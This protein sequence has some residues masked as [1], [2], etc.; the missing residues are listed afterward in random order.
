M[1]KLDRSRK[2]GTV[3]GDPEKFFYQDGVFFGANDL[4]VGEAESV[5]P[6][7]TQEPVSVVENKDGKADRIAKLKEV[8]IAKL[9]KMAATL[10]EELGV[11]PPRVAGTGVKAKLVK[12]IADRTE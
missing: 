3:Y 4:A 7:P 8:H 2:Y 10:A 9:K 1:K 5:E 11:D 12:W 6:V